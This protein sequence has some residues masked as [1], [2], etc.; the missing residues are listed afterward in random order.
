M[1]DT[2]PTVPETPGTESDLCLSIDRQI[3][4]GTL[5]R[6]SGIHVPDTVLVEIEHLGYRRAMLSPLQLTTSGVVLAV[7]VTVL[8]FGCSPSARVSAPSP[9]AVPYTTFFGTERDLYAWSG[10]HMALLTREPDLEAETIERLLESLDRV[11]EFLRDGTGKEPMRFF[12]HEGRIPI[13]VEPETCGVGCGML[14]ATGIELMPERFAEVYEAM[15]DT[16]RLELTPAYE[17]GRNF[18]FYGEAL[19][20]HDDDLTG[21]VSAGWARLVGLWGVEA[22]GCELAPHQGGSGEEYLATL[23]GLVDIYENDPDATFDS[24]LRVGRSVV[25]PLDLGASNLFAS[26]LLRVEAESGR[27]DFQRRFLRAVD[28]L[29][30]AGSTVEAVDNLVVAAS[31]A[32]GRDLCDDFAERWRF[33]LSPDA[34]RRVREALDD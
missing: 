15:R 11:Y 17:L 22:S 10:Q 28:E 25:N 12:E 29:P 18:W 23:R 24:T 26:F 30:P 4:Y 21:A 1:P 7:S 16:G 27:E 3:V 32:A 13:A 2:R 19:D 31:R 5:R 33:P 8:G 14:G 34:R 9:S 6:S 20:Y